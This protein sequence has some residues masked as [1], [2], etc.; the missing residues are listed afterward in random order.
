MKWVLSQSISISSFEA[1][2][3]PAARCFPL[4][5]NL[6]FGC[7]HASVQGWVLRPHCGMQPVEIWHA[8]SHDQRCGSRRCRHLCAVVNAIHEISLVICGSWLWCFEAGDGLIKAKM[9]SA[10]HTVWVQNWSS[11]RTETNTWARSSRDPFT[12]PCGVLLTF[13]KNFTGLET[14]FQSS[15]SRHVWVFFLKKSILIKLLFE[16]KITSANFLFLIISCCS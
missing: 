16:K 8:V 2:V 3:G 6:K 7:A 14:A 4:D 5:H 15:E 11:Y 10:L 1:A 9:S 12:A 13:C